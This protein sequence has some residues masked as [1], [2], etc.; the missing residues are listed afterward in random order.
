MLEIV[1]GADPLSQG[2]QCSLTSG[3]EA[4]ELK[5]TTQNMDRRVLMTFSPSPRFL[6]SQNSP[7]LGDN[8]SRWFCCSPGIP[9]SHTG[10]L[11]TQ[12][13]SWKPQF[14]CIRFI[15][16]NLPLFPLLFPLPV[17]HSAEPTARADVGSIYNIDFCPFRW[18]FA[19]ICYNFICNVSQTPFPCIF[20]KMKKKKKFTL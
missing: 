9:M 5:V 8:V 3:F 16:I 13:S 4:S 17:H 6:G 2:I 20:E 14:T 12:C 18:N 1:P 7:F 11:P 19:K 10:A 15:N